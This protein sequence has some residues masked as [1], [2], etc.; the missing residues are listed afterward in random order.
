ME[1][2][3]P[4]KNSRIPY[5]PHSGSTNSAPYSSTSIEAENFQEN[6]EDSDSLQDWDWW[7]CDSDPD[8]LFS[9]LRYRTSHYSIVLISKTVKL[10][11][12]T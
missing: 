5:Q 6:S 7:M 10:K 12:Q 8:I 2:Q 1:K 11:C 9:E 3:V 4:N